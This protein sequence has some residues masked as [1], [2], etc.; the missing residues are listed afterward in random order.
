MTEGR[1]PG[2]PSSHSSS[3]FFFASYLTLTAAL[4]TA[5]NEWRLLGGRLHATG[6]SRL[7]LFRGAALA[8]DIYALVAS[9]SRVPKL[10]TYAQI[11]VGALVGAGTHHLSLSLVSGS[12]TP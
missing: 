11:V 2:M 7:Q 4:D 3:L 8:F 12:S 6:D 10:H 1:G 9:I 5:S